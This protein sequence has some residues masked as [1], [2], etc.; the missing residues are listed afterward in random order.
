MAR[1]V[2]GSGQPVVDLFHPRVVHLYVD[3]AL[4]F[5]LA[6]DISNGQ[7]YGRLFAFDNHISMYTDQ[8]LRDIGFLLHKKNFAMECKRLAADADFQAG[9]FSLADVKLE[10]KEQLRYQAKALPC[11]PSSTSQTLYCP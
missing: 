11:E 5:V 1:D 3:N 6:P 9:G 4:L 8:K 2:S 7:R 10:W